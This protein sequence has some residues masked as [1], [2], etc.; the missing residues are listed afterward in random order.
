MFA[1]KIPKAIGKA[2]AKAGVNIKKSISLNPHTAIM[3]LSSQ[4]KRASAVPAFVV[5]AAGVS[6]TLAIG[7]ASKLLSTPS[8]RT[9]LQN[10]KALAALGD[11][12]AARG[13]MALH[14]ASQARASGK[15]VPQPAKGVQASTFKRVYPKSEVNALAA[16][17]APSKPPAKP[18]AKKPVAKTVAAAKVST[19]KTT[20]P[21]G[22]LTRIKRW[23]GR[24]L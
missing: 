12:D 3:G 19:G 24:I 14:A 11:P 20:A 10:T 16:R 2:A 23:F 18:P 21:V 13:L 17:K 8:A 6:G 1:L 9:A 5:P 22:I 4:L 15:P 7:A